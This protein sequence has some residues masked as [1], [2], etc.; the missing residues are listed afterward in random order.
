M[1]APDILA[2]KTRH[3]QA[4]RDLEALDTPE[5]GVLDRL[6]GLCARWKNTPGQHD[7]N[8]LWRP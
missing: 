4:L 6:T 7:A 5:E 2:N 1:Q 8:R 3:V